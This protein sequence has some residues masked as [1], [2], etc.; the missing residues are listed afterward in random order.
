MTKIMNMNTNNQQQPFHE[1]EV[2]PENQQ[3]KKFRKRGLFSTVAILAVLALCF[4]AYTRLNNSPFS[5]TDVISLDNVTKM[6]ITASANLFIVPT[7]GT[8]V[9]VSINGTS[10]ATPNYQASKNGNNLSIKFNKDPNVGVHLFNYNMT[11]EVPKSFVGDFSSQT[12]SGSTEFSLT[13]LGD[14]SISSSS[15]SI[16]ISP[17]KCKE[18]AVS[19]SSGQIH[20]ASLDADTAELKASSGKIKVR[21]ILHTNLKASSSSG[22]LD[23]QYADFNNNVKLDCS[24][25]NID[26]TLPRNSNFAIDAKTSSGNINC[27]FAVTPSSD[28]HNKLNGRTAPSAKNNIVLN[29]SS[30]NVTVKSN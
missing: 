13:N 23:I 10:T 25:G 12:S 9:K 3:K 11:I 8:D 4:F 29:A 24:S 19:A 6:N 17:L 1:N 22:G 16:D 27:D 21:D 2:Q 7:T 28:K 5:K 30:G 14:V 18:L 26:L 15:G 20:V